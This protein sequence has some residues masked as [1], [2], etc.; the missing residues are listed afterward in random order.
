MH[1]EAEKKVEQVSIQPSG[2]TVK[3]LPETQPTGMP[4]SRP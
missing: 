4:L 1:V 3:P 2:R